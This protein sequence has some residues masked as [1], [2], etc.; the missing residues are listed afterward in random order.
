[1]SP[2]LGT[3]SQKFDSSHPDFIWMK[4]I[5]QHERLQVEDQQRYGE[6]LSFGLL[7]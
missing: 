3:G 2:V 6:G 7:V 4:F 1:M 5:H